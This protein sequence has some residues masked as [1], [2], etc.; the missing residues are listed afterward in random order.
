MESEK[1]EKR[2]SNKASTDKSSKNVGK[3][4]LEKTIG[5]KAAAP[6]KVIELGVFVDSAALSLFMPYLG[7]REYVKLRELI[8]AFVNAVRKFPKLKELWTKDLPS[9]SL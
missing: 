4:A 9:N 3:N 8:L 5:S 7:T 1:I 6:N 2:K